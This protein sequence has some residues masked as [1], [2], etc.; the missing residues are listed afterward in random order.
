MSERGRKGSISSRSSMV[1]FSPEWESKNFYSFSCCVRPYCY[2]QQFY[3]TDVIYP[4]LLQLE[5]GV[6][7]QKIRGRRQSTV[8]SAWEKMRWRNI[9]SATSI[10]TLKGKKSVGFAWS[11]IARLCCQIAVTLCT[12]SVIVSGTFF[13]SISLSLSLALCSLQH[14]LVKTEK[15]WHISYCMYVHEASYHCAGSLIG[16]LYFELSS[17]NNAAGRML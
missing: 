8:E 6:Q 14:L 11:W 15:Y 16:L 9:N 5:R 7:M 10:R 1:S 4:S 12:C 13:I 3:R 2:E 17:G